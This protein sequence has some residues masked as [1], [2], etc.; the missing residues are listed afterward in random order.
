MPRLERVLTSSALVTGITGQDG[1]LMAKLLLSQGYRVIGLYRSSS[2]NPFWRLDELGIT[3]YLTLI[4]LDI[5]SY[6][7]LQTVLYGKRFSAIFHFAG[8]TLTVASHQNPSEVFHINT[9]A[10]LE[11]LNFAH[12][13]N[14]DCFLM[15][16]SSSEI[17]GN[18]GFNTPG[19]DKRLLRPLNPYG[20]SHTSIL[21]ISDMY[22]EVHGLEICNAIYFNHE[23]ALRDQ[24]FFSRKL[25]VGITQLITNP[26][27]ILDIGSFDSSRDWGSADEF[28]VVSLMLFEMRTNCALD[29]GT[30]KLT[31][32]VDVLRLALET[33]GFEP[34]FCLSPQE[35]FIIDKT[36]G[37]VLIRSNIDLVRKNETLPRTANTCGLYG[38]IN[39]IPNKT[40]LDI[41]PEMVMKDMKRRQLR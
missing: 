12:R 1:S 2:N 3:E 23:S 8:S 38:A 21:E 10:S 18:K 37:R 41:M 36:S 24:R 22:R 34:E 32:A 31:A 15:L 4:P 26:S 14:Q 6:G 27:F 39:R 40:L 19:F 29:I 17:Y 9:Y 11:L 13:T 7:D 35:N 5:S 25:S 16:A 20:L 33:A 28:M 30:G